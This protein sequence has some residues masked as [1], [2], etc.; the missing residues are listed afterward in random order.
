MYSDFFWCQ[1]SGDKDRGRGVHVFVYD[2]VFFDPFTVAVSVSGAADRYC[3]V[4]LYLGSRPDPSTYYKT[5]G[6]TK[7]HG[8][9]PAFP[10]EPLF[11]R[12]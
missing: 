8:L 11:P 3:N 4:L 1:R 9:N 10:Y 6:R 7:I 2:R 5:L 12:S